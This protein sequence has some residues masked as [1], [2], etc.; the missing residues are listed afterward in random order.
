MGLQDKPQLDGALQE[1]K[2]G[3]DMK[4]NNRKIECFSHFDYWCNM[5][6]K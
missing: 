6:R 2:I 1:N 3:K 4:N 5:R